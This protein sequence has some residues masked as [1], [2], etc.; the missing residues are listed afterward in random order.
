MHTTYGQQTSVNLGAVSTTTG[1]A[2]ISTSAQQRSLN[3]REATASPFKPRTNGSNSG[4][5]DRSLLEALVASKVFRD[6]ERA[7]TEATGLPVALRSVESWQLPHHGR[8]NEGPFCALLASA[9]R[10]CGGCLQNQEK[11]SQM[12][13]LATRTLNCPT[14]LCDT[15]VPVRLG[16]RLIGYLQ[17]G[18]VFRK[19]PTEAQFEQTM[20]LLANWG[21]DIPREE[22]KIAYF[23]SRVVSP[24]QHESI[25]KLLGIFAQ[26]LA[27]LSNQV[28]M[29]Q[30]NAEPPVITRARDYIHEHL[31]DG[32]R[33]GQVAKAVNT[34]PFYFC[35]IFKRATGINFT[36]YVSR[37]RIEKSKN[38][39]LNPNLRISEI[40]F[41]VGFQSLTHFN[42]VFKKILGQSPTQ[43]RQQLLGAR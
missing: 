10:A 11:L 16:D 42:R 3:V 2:P 43:Y 9:S 20:R 6:Y 35:K 13:T 1:G 15:A 12:A 4:S 39:L 14:G 25:I 36:D 30:A 22:L 17:T 8:R 31:T 41:E 21:V 34:S 7:F 24:K 37:V 40:A 27:M 29:Q 23:A 5:R 28:L 32:L 38:L 19:E 18:Q 26:H 33:L